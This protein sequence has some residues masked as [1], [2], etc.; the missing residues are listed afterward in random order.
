MS[1]E[2]LKGGLQAGNGARQHDEDKLGPDDVAKRESK[3]LSRCFGP[4]S[5]V[6]KVVFDQKSITFFWV[7]ETPTAPLIRT[8]QGAKWKKT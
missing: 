3:F 1:E 4:P 5:G 6:R 7:R 8:C 2:F